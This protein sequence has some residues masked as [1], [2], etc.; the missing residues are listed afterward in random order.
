MIRVA[1]VGDVHVGADSVGRVRCHLEHLPE[2][3]DVFL[4]AGDLTKR[5]LPEEADVLCDELRGLPDEVPT[6]AVLGNHDYESDCEDY[7]VKSLAGIG[8][9]VLEG[10]AAVVG[11]DGVSVGVA[12]AKGFGGGFAGACASEFGEP[13]AKAF[14]RHSIDTAARLEKALQEIRDADVRIALMHYA[15]VESTLRGERLEIYPF[16]GSYYLA[17]AVDRAGADLALHGHAHG[18][19]EKG[20]TPGGI[21]VRNVAQPV[22]RKAYS[23]YCLD[24]GG[25]V[26]CGTPAGAHA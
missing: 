16:L 15:P 22:L 17:E 13:A 23:V 18:G 20:V 19:S 12:G 25:E 1:A 9:Q 21:T 6:F 24:R 5:G 11:V 8:V 4:L 3:A 7:V 10:D 2:R 26:S 14:V